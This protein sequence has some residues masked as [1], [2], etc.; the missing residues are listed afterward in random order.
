M[1]LVDNLR[2]EPDICVIARDTLQVFKEDMR[3]DTSYDEM[4]SQLHTMIEILVSLP[5]T[6]T[7]CFFQMVD[8]ELSWTL[9]GHPIN[10]LTH[11]PT[12]YTYIYTLGSNG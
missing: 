11:P 1:Q 9:P 4:L 7:G 2:G 5:P 3:R 10:M 6:P 12:Q 8:G